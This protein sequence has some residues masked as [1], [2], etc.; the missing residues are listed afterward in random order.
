MRA[1]CNSQHFNRRMWTQ[2]CVD[3][4][5]ALHALDGVTLGAGGSGRG[6]HTPPGATQV[7]AAVQDVGACKSL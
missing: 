5:A 7:L 3:Q 2:K 4:G 6:L 1:C